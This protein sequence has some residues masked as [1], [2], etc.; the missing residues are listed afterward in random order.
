MRIYKKANSPFWWYDFTANGKRIRA[1]TKRSIKDKA[2]AT[3][4]LSLEY[5]KALN[6]NQLGDKPEVTLQEAFDINLAEVSGQTLRLYQ[7]VAGKL[8][9]SLGADRR[10]DHINQS[11]IDKLIAQ[12]RKEGL[13]ANTIKAELKFLHRTMTRLCKTYKVNRDIDWPKIKGFTKTRYLLDAEEVAILAL[14]NAAAETNI[15]AEKARDLYL[16]LVDTGVRLM[17][18]V[19]LSWADID[20]TRREITVYRTKTNSVSLV[21]ITDRVFVSLNRRRNQEAPFVK[22]EFAIRH[23]R[24]VIAGECNLD[25]RQITTRGRATIHTLRDTFASRLVQ[26]GMSIHR[27]AKL[28]GHSNTAMTLKYAQL[29]SQDVLEEARRYM[30]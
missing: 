10:L 22:M 8:I 21:P 18:G 28:L 23:L 6:I 15:T 7:S 19:N 11:D 16:L 17:E 2:G 13:K 20:M 5:E 30:Q 24:K 26:R 27:L 1:S 9:T 4:V 25:E 3:R 12:R 29:E 14:L